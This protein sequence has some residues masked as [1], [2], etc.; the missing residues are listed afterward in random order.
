MN[1]E[2]TTDLFWDCECD[3]AY[4]HL[5]SEETCIRCGMSH[6]EMPDSHTS[7]VEA[8]FD[9]HEAVIRMAVQRQG[10]RTMPAGGQEAIDAGL[11]V[12][13]DP[14]WMYSDAIRASN[15]FN[16]TFLGQALA[17]MH[18]WTCKCAG[19]VAVADR[20]NVVPT[21]AVDDLCY[22]CEASIARFGQRILNGQRACPMCVK[23]RED[24]D[25]GIDKP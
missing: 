13:S 10:W 3:T 19:H 18:G 24:L 12:E 22:N 15:G 5:K 21:L 6:N 17:I 20:M 16:L 25:K 1:T 14:T 7:E 2:I 8:L 4:I 23:H 11:V 9:T